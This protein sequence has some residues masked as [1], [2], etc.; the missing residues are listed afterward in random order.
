[1][2]AAIVIRSSIPSPAPARAPRSPPE[3]EAH[4]CDSGGD[5]EG[6]GEALVVGQ[7]L[8]GEADGE[9]QAGGRGPADLLA[10]PE[11]LRRLVLALSLGLGPLFP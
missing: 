2:T 4:P 3:Q 7:H 5:P 8:D 9:D 10:L 11:V 1:M 6:D